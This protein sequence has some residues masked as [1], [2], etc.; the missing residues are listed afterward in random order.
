VEE[1]LGHHEPLIVDQ[2]HRLLGQ[3]GPLPRPLLL[4]QRRQL[5][6]LSLSAHVA[7]G[8]SQAVG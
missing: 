1:R 2:Q 5:L 4:L 6:R 7:P 8:V 3:R